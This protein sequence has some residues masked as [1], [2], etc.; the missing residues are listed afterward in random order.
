MRWVKVCGWVGV[1]CR[2]V[3][4]AVGGVLGKVVGS[5]GEEAIRVRMRLRSG[6]KRVMRRYCARWYRWAGES[7]S[8]GG[9]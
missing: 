3:V 2:A 1:G 8:R 9:M 7:V 5:G 4:A 6:R